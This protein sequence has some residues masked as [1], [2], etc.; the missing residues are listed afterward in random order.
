MWWKIS[1]CLIKI[2]ENFLIQFKITR[3]SNE[4][5]YKGGKPLYVIYQNINKQSF[6]IQEYLIREQNSF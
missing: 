5:C 1:L 4:H 2:N 6:K 3:L